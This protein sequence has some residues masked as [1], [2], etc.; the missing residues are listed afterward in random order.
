MILI[1]S[2]RNIFNL[3]NNTISY[4]NYNNYDIDY[5]KIEETLTN[6]FLLNKK[7]FSNEINGITYK[8]D[9]YLNNIFPIFI[10]TKAQIEITE[11]DKK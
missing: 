3:S 4:N 8:N 10:N 1:N 9:N 11:D 2:K 6:I 7:L 5:N